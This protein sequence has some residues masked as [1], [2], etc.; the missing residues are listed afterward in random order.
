MNETVKI[1]NVDLIR[2]LLSEELSAEFMRYRVVPSRNADRLDV[3]IFGATSSG[4]FLDVI[5]LQK[6]QRVLVG[7][8]PD[9]AGKVLISAGERP[10][11]GWTYLEISV[12]TVDLKDEVCTINEK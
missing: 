8:G 7:P 1:P 9:G 2:D 5:D 3:D 11:D 4:P 12:N 10:D 6:I